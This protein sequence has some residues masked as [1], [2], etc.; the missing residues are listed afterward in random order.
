MYDYI[1]IELPKLINENFNFSKSKIG[2]FGH[3][4]GGGGAI[5][6]AIKN[7]NL[8]KRNRTSCSNKRSFRF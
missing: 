4:M 2:I 7:R 6:C 3:S 5:Q 8:F 1:C